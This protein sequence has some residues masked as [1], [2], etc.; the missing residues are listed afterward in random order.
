[1]LNQ[2]E[3]TKYSLSSREDTGIEEKQNLIN[4]MLWSKRY[5]Q[6]SLS[7]WDNH[8]DEAGNFLETLSFVFVLATVVACPF[9]HHEYEK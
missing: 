5:Q 2:S 1:M 6:D 8:Q 4:F 9:T 3:I 7:I